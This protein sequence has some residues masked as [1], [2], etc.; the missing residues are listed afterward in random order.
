MGG[1][2]PDGGWILA[3]IGTETG[4]GRGCGGGGGGGGG[5]EGGGETTGSW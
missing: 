1:E 3:A 2:W 5:F 4:D